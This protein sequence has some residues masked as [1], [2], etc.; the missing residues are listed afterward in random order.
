MDGGDDVDEPLVMPLNVVDEAIPDGVWWLSL[1]WF[2]AFDGVG[3]TA[4]VNSMPHKHHA[5][6]V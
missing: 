4:P 2:P 6:L 1:L 5:W 3:N